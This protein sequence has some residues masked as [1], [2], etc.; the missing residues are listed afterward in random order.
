MKSSNRIL[1][2]YKAGRTRKLNQLR[3]KAFDKLK[4]KSVSASGWVPNILPLSEGGVQLSFNLGYGLRETSF[5]TRE[6]ALDYIL[7]VFC[8]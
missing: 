4:E 5:A 1:A 2:G 6:A 3:Q 8:C 7:E